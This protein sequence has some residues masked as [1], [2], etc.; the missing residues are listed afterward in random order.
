MSM[1]ARDAHLLI[2]GAI[3]CAYFT[4][5]TAIGLYLGRREDR[6]SVV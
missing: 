4:M 1:P 6:K 2:D 3:V 5:I